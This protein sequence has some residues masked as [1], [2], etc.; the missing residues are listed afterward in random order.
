[1]VF[2]SALG[3][4]GR[5]GAFFFAS[6]ISAPRSWSCL[7]PRPSR[8]LGNHSFSSSSMWW[9]TFS[10]RTVVFAVNR[11]SD[12]AVEIAI[13]LQHTGSLSLVEAVVLTDPDPLLDASDLYVL[14]DTEEELT[15]ERYAELLSK[16]RAFLK[17]D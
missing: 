11:S 2:F 15:D 12:H 17:T 16:V 4:D 3:W 13:D 9:S 10:I 14:H 6:I 1:M 7:R 5:F 8:T